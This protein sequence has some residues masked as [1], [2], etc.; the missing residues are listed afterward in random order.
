MDEDGV[1][2]PRYWEVPINNFDNIFTSMLAFFEIATLENWV[3]MLWRVIDSQDEDM[4][5]LRGNRSYMAIM[6]VVFIFI[7]TFFVM[8]LFI[9]VIVDKFNEEIRKREGSHNFS[10]E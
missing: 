9:S 6:F 4:G 10:E 2:A 7:T 3:E 8:N 5:P 1:I